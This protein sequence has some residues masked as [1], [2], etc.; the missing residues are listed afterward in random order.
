MT[1]HLLWLFL[2]FVNF[3]AVN[4]VEDMMRYISLY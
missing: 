4:D 1:G 2:N 3:D